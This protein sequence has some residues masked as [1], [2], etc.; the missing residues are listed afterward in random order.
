MLPLHQRGVG[1]AG[2]EPACT[3]T[4]SA[5]YKPEGI[6]PGW[7]PRSRTEHYRL[8][9]AAPSTG[10][11]VTNGLARHPGARYA[12]AFTPPFEAGSG[13][14]PRRTLTCQERKVGVSSPTAAKP[15]RVFKA[16]CRAGGAPSIGFHEESGR[17][18]LQ[19]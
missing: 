18:E 17:L 11:V 14:H 6:R 3:F 10:W 5:G 7:P 8:I 16:R 12:L 13:T 2:V 19:R 9:R 15:S 4:L 1:A